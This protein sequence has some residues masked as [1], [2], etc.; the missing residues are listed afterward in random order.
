MVGM[1]DCTNFYEKR[2]QKAL[3][4]QVISVII[5]IRIQGRKEKEMSKLLLPLR[6]DDDEIR[7][8]DL[9]MKGWTPEMM[10]F[11]TTR[12]GKISPQAK[13][14]KDAIERIISNMIKERE[15]ERKE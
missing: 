3:N 8:L 11:V 6:K 5:L 10:E 2:T 12:K 1:S 15:K 4:N 14:I 9:I 7:A 13:R